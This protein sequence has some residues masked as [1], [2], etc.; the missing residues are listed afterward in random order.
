VWTR[1]GLDF[2][3]EAKQFS[4]VKA[5]PTPWRMAEI[6]LRLFQDDVPLAD[7]ISRQLRA[8]ESSASDLTSISIVIPLLSIPR[9]SWTKGHGDMTTDMSSLA[10]AEPGREPTA[11]SACFV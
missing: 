2:C 8:L 5:R 4:H 6:R 10:N 3:N 1:K 11:S 9:L 7:T